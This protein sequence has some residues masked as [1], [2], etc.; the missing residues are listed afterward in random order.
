LNR[1]GGLAV[2][3]FALLQDAGPELINTVPAISVFFKP[4]MYGTRYLKELGD[5]VVITW[6]LT[7]PVGGI[8]DMTWTPT[9]N[10]FQAV[11]RKDGTIDLSYN[12]VHAQDAI[13]GVYP[14][15]T[16][17]K[18]KTLA[19]IS[20]AANAAARERRRVALRRI[21]A[22]RAARGEG[23]GE[24]HHGAGNPACGVRR[25]DAGLRVCCCAGPGAFSGGRHR[26]RAGRDHGLERAADRGPDR[27]AAGQTHG[28]R[29]SCGGP[30]LREEPGRSISGGV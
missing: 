3:R 24:Q 14:M 8:Q 4:R 30:L 13:V 16:A 7:E 18:E 28:P 2:D 27:A 20:A 6:S 25:R 29:Q 26:R 17:G 22:G 15:V 21:R 1:G 9:V 10:R 12:D 11:L 23:R 5:R 19:T